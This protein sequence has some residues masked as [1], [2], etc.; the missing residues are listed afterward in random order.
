MMPVMDGYETASVIRDPASSVR[1]HAIP[2]IALTANV[3]T[4]DHDR[5]F[6]VGMDA[7]LS[8][9]IAFADLL[10]LLGK[11]VSKRSADGS[12][13]VKATM[14][15]RAHSPCE[16][17]FKMSEFVTSNLDDLDLAREVGTVFIKSAPE[18]KKSIREAVA[19]KD[20]EKIRKSAHKLKGA[21]ANLALPLLSEAAGM[22]EA[23]AM[24]G[25]LEKAVELLPQV[26]QR[27]EEAEEVLNR[28]LLLSGDVVCQ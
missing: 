18:Y 28:L 11:W 6:E 23:F 27:L 26:E 25:Q 17:I 16:E 9:P 2:I 5:C 7:Y 13:P 15:A 10:A 4:D 19:A 3:F 22:I 20:V 12:G 21:A 8:K 24:A 1:N 14:V